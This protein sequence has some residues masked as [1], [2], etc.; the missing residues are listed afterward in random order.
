MFFTNL[1]IEDTRWLNIWLVSDFNTPKGR[2]LLRNGLKSIKKLANLRLSFVQNGINNKLTDAKLFYSIIKLY[3]SN[4]AKQ[5]LN[6]LLGPKLENEQKI[7]NN[8]DFYL[9]RLKKNDYNDI[10]VHVSFSIFFE[11]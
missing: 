8:N 10:S 4:I 5:M 9:Q 2:N 7:N 1:D 3:S 11:Y 6:K